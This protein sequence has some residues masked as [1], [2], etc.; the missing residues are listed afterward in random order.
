MFRP[1]LGPTLLFND[2][3]GN[4]Q[5]VKRPGHDVDHPPPRNAKVKNEG[6]CRPTSTPPVHLW[7]VDMQNFTYIPLSNLLAASSTFVVINYC[8]VIFALLVRLVLLLCISDKPV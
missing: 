4:F 5:G 2:Y 8:S 7:G 1:A 6:R 3:R